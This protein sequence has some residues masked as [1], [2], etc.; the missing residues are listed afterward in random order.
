MRDEQASRIKLHRDCVGARLSTTRDIGFGNP[1]RKLRGI[2]RSW[3]SLLPALVFALVLPSSGRAQSVGNPAPEFSATS[4]DGLKHTLSGYRG[5]VVLLDF[6]A[7][8]CGP[9]RKELPFLSELYRSIHDTSLVFL[10]INLDTEAEARTDFLRTLHT[11]LP[12]P[13]IPDADGSLPSMYKIPGMP[14]VVMIDR[15]GTVRYVHSG[16][17]ESFEDSYY[18][19]LTGLLEESG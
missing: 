5:K 11:R 15:G 4:V 19:E 1:Q 12:F 14:T 6:W 7:S 3:T 8:W 13:V 17:R 9:C 10:A 2:L 16:F 18:D